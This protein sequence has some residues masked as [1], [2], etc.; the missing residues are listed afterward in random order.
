MRIPAT[1]GPAETGPPYTNDGCHP[2]QRLAVLL[3]PIRPT[4]LPEP[5]EW[6]D[7]DYAGEEEPPQPTEGRARV[8]G[9]WHFNHAEVENTLKKKKKMNLTS[10]SSLAQD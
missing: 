5:E 8:V 10:Y 2:Q 6:W 7:G 3:Y 9:R 1:S 4:S